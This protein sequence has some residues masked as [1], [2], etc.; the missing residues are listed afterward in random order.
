MIISPKEIE[1]LKIIEPVE[2]DLREFLAKL[3]FN[4]GGGEVLSFEHIKSFLKEGMHK[5][6][7]ADMLS[8]FIDTVRT[9]KLT[10]QNI[11]Q[12]IG[13][14]AKSIVDLHDKITAEYVN[15]ELDD[16][17]DSQY[18]KA[19]APFLDFT[20]DYENIRIELISTL[21]ELNTEG[22]SMNHCIA[23]YHDIITNKQY[24]GFRVFNKETNE[25]LTLGC[26]RQDNQL[27]FN[28][29]KGSWNS[30]AQKSSCLAIVNFCKLKK[31]PILTNDAFDLMPAFTN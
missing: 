27:I 1:E 18:K 26:Y 16:L 17:K 23:T 6:E 15:G 29:L 31:I 5:V 30:P 22:S 14:D 9:L 28:Q 24:V 8:I 3:H 25:R 12:V 20:G 21:E 11:N 10:N 19:V 7:S 2:K 13:L 4:Y